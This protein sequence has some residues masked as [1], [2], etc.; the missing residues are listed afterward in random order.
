MKQN[1][2]IG[3]LLLAMVMLVSAIFVSGCSFSKEWSYRAN[4]KELPIGVYIYALDSAYAQAQS[5]AQEQVEDYATNSDAWLNEEIEDDDGN[6]QIANEWIKEH[7]ETMCLSYLVIDEQLEKEGATVDEATME[8]ADSQAETLWNVGQYASYGII[9]GMKDQLEPYG[10]S[11][12][13]FKY[14][15][16]EYQSKASAL[17]SKIYSAE[18]SKAVSDDEVKKYY[19]DNYVDFNYLPVNLYTTSTDDDGNSTNTALSDDESKKLISEI[20]GYAD[21]L[22][23]GKSFTTIVEDYMKANSIT[24]DPSQS[25]TEQLDSESFSLGDDIKNALKELENKKATTVQVGTGDSA[26]YYLIYKNNIEDS[27]DSVIDG[28]SESVTR[29]TIVSIMKQDEFT[30]YIEDLAKNLEHEKNSAVDSYNPN[31]FFVSVEPTTTATEST[32]ETT[33]DSDSSTAE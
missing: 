5:Y 25:S 31:M 13:S 28:T 22:N 14:C 3:S 26:I 4:G 32:D 27:A 17:F 2:K 33:A 19:T 1:L 10:I 20:D 23:S 24:T 9:N 30:D 11:Y 15:T 18:G 7:A 16:T 12:D 8:S 29:D 6:K 21:E